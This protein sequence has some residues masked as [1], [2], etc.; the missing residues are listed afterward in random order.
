MKLAQN[1]RSTVL[2]RSR[3]KTKKLRDVYRSEF[4]RR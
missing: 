4:K 1:E 2:L 3:L